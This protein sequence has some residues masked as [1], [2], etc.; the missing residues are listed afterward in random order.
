MWYSS[1]LILAHSYQKVKF[2]LDPDI[3]LFSIFDLNIG[4]LQKLTNI[5]CLAMQVYESGS[6]DVITH[7]SSILKESL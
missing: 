4:F 6:V 2:S 7:C 3:E 5:D 1:T